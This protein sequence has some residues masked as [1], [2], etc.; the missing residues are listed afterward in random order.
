MLRNELMIVFS[1]LFFH[2]LINLTE[3]NIIFVVG[4]GL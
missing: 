4:F 1:L 3:I 2:N